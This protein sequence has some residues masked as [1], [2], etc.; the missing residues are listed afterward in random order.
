M[1]FK[2]MSR[3]TEAPRCTTRYNLKLPP[4]L[5]QIFTRYD[6]TQSVLHRVGGSAS[7]ARRDVRIG[8]QCKGYASV[9]QKLLDVLG[10]YVA[11]E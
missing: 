8:V 2:R 10:V 7:H 6:L 4:V 5:W 11:G 3:R 1:R 9:P